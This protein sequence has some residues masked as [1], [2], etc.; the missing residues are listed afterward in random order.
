MAV[1]ILL[2]DDHQVV[3]LG[4][5]T[6]LEAEPDFKVVG[7]ASN[8][9]EAKTLVERLRPDI[10]VL[11]LMM[12][13]LNGMEVTRQVKQ[14]AP[15]TRIIILSMQATEAYVLEALR[16]GASGYVLKQAD[17]SELIQ[18]I[19][20]VMEGRD[21]LSPEFTQRA[22]EAYRDKA[23]AASSNLYDSLT[24]RE[25]EVFQMAAEGLTTAEIAERLFLSPR[26][27]EMHRGNLMRKLGLRNQ[28]ELVRYAIWRGILPPDQQITQA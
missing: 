27:V 23:E 18:A 25:R 19:R 11:D 9:L 8:G 12:P 3:R 6:L 14:F 22:I 15:Q 24:A 7:E 28:T 16:N 20:Q 5:K 21:Y 17:M 26:T 10:L 1:S 2:A 4:V 13:G